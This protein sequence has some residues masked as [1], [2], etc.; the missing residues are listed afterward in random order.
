LIKKTKTLFD[1]F[2]GDPSFGAIVNSKLSV[3]NANQL[4]FTRPARPVQVHKS[5]GVIYSS[6]CPDEKTFDNT[7]D[8]DNVPWDKICSYCNVGIFIFL[9]FILTYDKQKRNHVIAAIK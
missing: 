4:K 6:K 1:L 5:H 2:A 3:T 7:K 9:F 8:S